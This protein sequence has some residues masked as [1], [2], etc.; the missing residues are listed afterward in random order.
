VE[1]GGFIIFQVNPGEADYVLT[2][3]ATIADP[4]PPK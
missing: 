4:D 3:T 2:I 1:D